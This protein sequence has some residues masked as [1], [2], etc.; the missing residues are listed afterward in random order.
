M[1]PIWSYPYFSGAS[2]LDHGRAWF[3]SE[4]EYKEIES[5]LSNPDFERVLQKRSFDSQSNLRQFHLNDMGYVYVIAVAKNIFPFLSDMDAVEWL[6]ILV[7]LL[8][9]LYLLYILDSKWMRLGFLFLYVLN[10][11]IISYVTY[12]FYYYWQAI[13][14]LMLIPYLV[15]KKHHYSWF[16]VPVGVLLGL[17]IAIRPTVLFLCIYLIYL[18]RHEKKFLLML[19]MLTMLASAYLL[20]GADILKSPWHTAYISIG[21]Y[22]NPDGLVFKDLTAE[23]YFYDKTG[24]RVNPDLPSGDLLNP[25]RYHSYANVVKLGYLDYLVQH[26]IRLARNGAL[27]VLQS[28]SLGYFEYR[29][30]QYSYLSAFLGLLFVIFLIA[31]RSWLFLIGIL[32]AGIGFTPYTPPVTRYLFGSFPL[33]IC[34]AIYTVQKMSSRFNR[35]S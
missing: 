30:I 4:D 20:R 22:E 1:H 19:S 35:R 23:D 7:H 11:L 29:D 21:A 31:T 8:T 12:P 24:E 18:A 34:A 32:V 13:P 28:F 16:L 25:D 26:P 2:N 5:L 14:A 15:R 6:Q 27:N 10:P 33:I 3:Y 9:S 17:S